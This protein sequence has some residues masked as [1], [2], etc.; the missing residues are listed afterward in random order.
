V[1]DIFTREEW[2]KIK[3]RTRGASCATHTLLGNKKVKPLSLNKL[4]K[5]TKFK[6]SLSDIVVK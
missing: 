4:D 5:N 2:E 6:C 3:E 1:K